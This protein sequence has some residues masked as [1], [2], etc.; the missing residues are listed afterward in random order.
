MR[1][2]FAYALA[3]TF[4]AGLASSPAL[5]KDECKTVRPLSKRIACVEKKADDAAAALVALDKKV[6]A[7]PKG[8]VTWEGLKGVKVEW[9]AHPGVCLY[10]QDWNNNGG[11]EH[12]ARTVLG[13][14]N[15]H[16]MFNIRK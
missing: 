7:L 6:A 16:Y 5:A 9:T 1:L 11:I 3:G 2:F 13:C 14:N 8:D 12:S 10:F 4:A 15:E